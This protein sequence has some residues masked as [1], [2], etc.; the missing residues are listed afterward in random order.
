M[1]KTGTV[2]LGM[3]AITGLVICGSDAGTFL[4]QLLTSTIGIIIFAGSMFGL[5]ALN[6]EER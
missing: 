4:R 6:R 3:F 1:K 2:L 5:I